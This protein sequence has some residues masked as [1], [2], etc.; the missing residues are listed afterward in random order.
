MRK[1]ESRNARGTCEIVIEDGSRSYRHI[2]E[3]ARVAA[4][5]YEKGSA[6]RASGHCG[7]MLARTPAYWPVRKPSR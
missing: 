6:K 4:R 3:T 2:T 1:L 7:D 5:H